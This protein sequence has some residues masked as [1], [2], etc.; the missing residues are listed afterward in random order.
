MKFEG[1]DQWG[2]CIPLGVGVCVWEISKNQVKFTVYWSIQHSP[3]CCKY[4]HSPQVLQ[5]W[6]Y[7][8]VSWGDR[9]LPLAAWQSRNHRCAEILDFQTHRH[10]EY[11]WASGLCAPP[12]GNPE[13]IGDK[14]LTFSCITRRQLQIYLPSLVAKCIYMRQI[15]PEL[16]IVQ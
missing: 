9:C 15:V 13:N 8:R 6:Q 7:S 10:T 1:H 11:Y 4:N 12:V 5:S 14:I 3:F 2:F 16:L